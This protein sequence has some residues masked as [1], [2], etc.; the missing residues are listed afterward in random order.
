MRWKVKGEVLHSALSPPKK[1]NRD[2]GVITLKDDRWFMKVRDGADIVLTASRLTEK[3]ME[4]YDKGDVDYIGIRIDP[5]LKIIPNDE[6]V[7]TIEM[8]ERRLVVKYDS[9]TTQIPTTVPD[10]VDGH[11]SDTPSI[12]YPFRMYGDL[13][14]IMDFVKDTHD[15]IG[16]TAIVIRAFSEGLVL[17]AEDNDSTTVVTDFI[18]KD[19]MDGYGTHWEKASVNGNGPAG[20]DPVEDETIE[21]MYSTEVVKDVYT[22]GSEG[23]FEYENS[24]PF[25]VV[26]NKTEGLTVSWIVTPRLNKS[27]DMLT[28]PESVINQYPV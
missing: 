5:S 2:E 18:S 7:V 25:R 27:G 10:Y 22:L 20:I 11:M 19:D 9:R 13:S 23:R 26:D 21:A 17:Y 8:E 6:T 4:E 12:D 24:G 28:V 16:D 15:L 1:I 3:G 14:N